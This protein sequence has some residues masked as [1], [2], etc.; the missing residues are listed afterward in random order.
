MELSSSV[1]K[2]GSVIPALYTCDGRNISP[3]LTFEF[4]PQRARSLVLIVDDPDAPGGMWVHWTV[5]DIQP[6]VKEIAA[7][8]VPLGAREGVTSFG[9]T[10]YGGPCPPNGRH[11]YFFKLYALDVVL[12]LKKGASFAELEVAMSGH[13]I[14]RAELVGVYERVSGE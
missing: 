7:N 2:A 6:T 9:A 5:W 10:G 12:S 8:S 3:P 14:A 1:F 4:V 13:M 11:R